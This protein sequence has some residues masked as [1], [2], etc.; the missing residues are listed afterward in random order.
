MTCQLT[1]LHTFILYHHDDDNDV[2]DDAED[3]N[4][5]V[6]ERLNN[7]LPH[8]LV[9]VIARVVHLGEVC[10]LRRHIVLEGAV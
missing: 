5:N 10:C 3:D 4:G 8:G 7:D 9:L 6:E 1:Y 2:A